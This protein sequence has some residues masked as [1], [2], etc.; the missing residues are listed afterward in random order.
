MRTQLNKK[1]WDVLSFY[2]IATIGLLILMFSKP[3]EAYPS[4]QYPHS[5]TDQLIVEHLRL[6]VS[7]EDRKDWLLAEKKTWEPWLKKQKGFINRQL[8]WDEKMEEAIVLITWESRSAWKNIPQEEIEDVQKTF[9]KIAR[10]STG[11]K[12]EN[13]FPLI[14]EG[15]LLAQ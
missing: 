3:Q 10:D 5:L 11:Q 9:E 4:I 6:H 14:F 2:L 15:E 13:P 7:K 12:D 1:M 8:F